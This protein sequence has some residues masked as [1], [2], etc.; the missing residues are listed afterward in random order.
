MKTRVSLI[1]A[2]LGVL[3]LFLYSNGEVPH[4]NVGEGPNASA[5]GGEEA[6]SARDHVFDESVSSGVTG[7]YGSS[8]T[9]FVTDTNARQ[10]NAVGFVP[11]DAELPGEKSAESASLAEKREELDETEE[12]VIYV[13]AR[14]ACCRLRRAV[15]GR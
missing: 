13:P 7:N 2:T 8:E 11:P 14:L 9:G 5:G 10:K 1:L 6:H 4:E 12:D 15:S 3:V